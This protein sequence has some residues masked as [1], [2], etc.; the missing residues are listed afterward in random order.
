MGR[1]R[2]DPWP[3]NMEDLED[4]WYNPERFD[5]KRRYEDKAHDQVLSPTFEE[6]LQEFFSPLGQVIKIPETDDPVFDFIIPKAKLLIEAKSLNV[7]QLSPEGHSNFPESID[8]LARNINKQIYKTEK[9][10]VSYASQEFDEFYKILVLGFD[11][12]YLAF[13]AMEIVSSP[14]FIRSTKY[15]SSKIDGIVFT[16]FPYPVM[17]QYAPIAYVKSSSLQRILQKISALKGVIILQ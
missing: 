16:G 9:K 4:M 5:D 11:S 3:K 15:S 6:S 12:I 17:D 7:R 8:K 13:G 14:D 1:K 10:L 2:R